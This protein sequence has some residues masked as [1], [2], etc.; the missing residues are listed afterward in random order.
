MTPVITLERR[1]YGRQTFTW[2]K[3][4]SKDGTW[5]TYGDPWPSL[6]IPKKQLALALADIKSREGEEE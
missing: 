6:T 2:L 4:Q 1:R 5:Q 3:W